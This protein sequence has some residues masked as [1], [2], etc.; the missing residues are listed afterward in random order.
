MSIEKATARPEAA[1]KRE[2]RENFPS[3]R[4]FVGSAVAGMLLAAALPAVAA[5]P[6]PANRSASGA[7]DPVED[8]LNRYGS[9]FGDITRVV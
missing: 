6:A 7:R 3:R 2:Q 5:S 8:I 9:E 4:D 1:G